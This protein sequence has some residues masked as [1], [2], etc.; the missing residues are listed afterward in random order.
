MTFDLKKI[1]KLSLS[2][3]FVG[4]EKIIKIKSPSLSK[5]ELE[6]KTV[7]YQNTENHKQIKKRELY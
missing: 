5:Q 3:V 1:W 7:N 4:F 2:F 6:Q